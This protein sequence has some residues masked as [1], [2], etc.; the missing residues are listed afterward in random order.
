MYEG[1]GR[2]RLVTTPEIIKKRKFRDISRESHTV[3]NEVIEHFVK[4]D[5]EVHITEIETTI[6]NGDAD[7][8]QHTVQQIGEPTTC[9]C[10]EEEKQRGDSVWSI[11]K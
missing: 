3:G 9:T 5:G 11:F 2:R 4:C 7:T 1:F 10:T 8:E 6:L